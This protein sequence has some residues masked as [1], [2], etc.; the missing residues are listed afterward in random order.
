MDGMFQL[1]DLERDG[2]SMAKSVSDPG[3]DGSIAKS[4]GLMEIYCTKLLEHA[5]TKGWLGVLAGTS[6]DGTNDWEGCNALLHE[7]LHD[8]IPISIYIRLH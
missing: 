7:L 8:T 6:D 3:T 1:S 4:L 5:A 2:E